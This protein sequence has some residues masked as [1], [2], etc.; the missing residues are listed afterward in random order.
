MPKIP[1]DSLLKPV[2]GDKPCG[3]PLDDDIALSNLW[4]EIETD[5]KGKPEQQFGDTIVEAKPPE[6]K[7]V[8]GKCL[9]LLGSCR[10]LGP[11]VYLTAAATDLDGIPGFRDG[12]KLIH[13]FV[14][15]FWTDLHPLPD[16]DEPEDFYERVGIFEMMTLEYMQTPSDTLRFVERVRKSPL[17][18]SRQTGRI[19]HADILAFRNGSD[20]APTRD[21]IVA[22]FADTDPAFLESVLSAATEAASLIRS[23]QEHAA[24]LMKGDAPSFT[25]LRKEIDAMVAAIGEFTAPAAAAPA[26]GPAQE[27]EAAASGTAASAPAY[28]A[29][30]VAGVPGTIQSRADVV[31]TLN[32][33]ISYYRNNEPAS[34]VPLLLERAKKLVNNDFLGIIRNFRPDLERDFLAILGVSEYEEGSIEERSYQPPPPVAPPVNREPE[35]PQ[36]DDP[37]ANVKI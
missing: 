37:W 36:R 33:I 4:R 34:P 26:P 3:P 23:L 5:A 35:P 15:T 2:S 14:E 16:P 13:G 20:G 18:Q 11:A 21:L 22:A 19:T 29:T 32:T 27:G 10:H 9:D 31:R 17:A 30:A 24:G 1:V 25:N 6:W 7:Q 8:H 28:A 12:L